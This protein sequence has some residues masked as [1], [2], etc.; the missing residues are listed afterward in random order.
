VG[1]DVG[2]LFELPVGSGEILRRPLEFG[3]RLAL[4]GDV[5]G[6]AD[7]AQHHALLVAGEDPIGTAKGPP[8]T[9][10]GLEPVLQVE[11]LIVL[12]RRQSAVVVDDRFHVVGMEDGG[13]EIRPHPPDLLGAPAERG[14]HAVIGEGVPFLSEAEDGDDLG[15]RVQ[16]RVD[17]GLGF[18]QLPL[19]GL[20]FG[21][22]GDGRERPNVFSILHQRA[23]RDD[24]VHRGA[25]GVFPFEFVRGDAPDSPVL[26]LIVQRAAARLGE[27]C[28][29]RLTDHL[30]RPAPDHLA[31]TV[32]DEGESA[33]RVEHPEALPEV[34]DEGAVALLA[35]PQPDL[36]LHLIRQVDVSAEQPADRAVV[37]DHRGAPGLDPAP[38]TVLVTQ[39]EPSQP[40]SRGRLD[41]GLDGRQGLVAIRLVEEH[42][43]G[44]EGVLEFVV[45]IAELGL[46]GR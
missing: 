6:R 7:D 10:G 29:A 13:E 31:E 30:V 20:E 19:D 16:H 40:H 2:E 41:P 21:D 17:E 9:G 36:G 4:A 35:L 27:K 24:G 22:V 38:S 8:F 44:V 1:G 5:H 18:L 45:S 23:G 12:G 32:V 25:V 26:Q 28:S 37:V 42:R 15:N 3:L 43:E 34:L 33:V 46:P 39:T 11:H 14:V